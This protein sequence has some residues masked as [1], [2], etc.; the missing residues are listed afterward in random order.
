MPVID[1]EQL[2]QAVKPNLVSKEA[3]TLAHQLIEEYEIT[4]NDEMSHWLGES[5]CKSHQA[6]RLW[7]Q[8]QLGLLDK[9]ES[10]YQRYRQLRHL[11]QQ[12]LPDF[13]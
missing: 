12:T 9:D 2:R 1:Y 13:M 11:F 4:N 6:L 5:Q 7:V 10:E 3:N 8:R